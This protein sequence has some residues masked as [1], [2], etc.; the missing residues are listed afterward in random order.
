MRELKHIEHTILEKHKSLSKLDSSAGFNGKTFDPVKIFAQIDVDP[1]K[2]MSFGPKRNELVSELKKHEDNYKQKFTQAIKNSDLSEIDHEMELIES[3]EKIGTLNRVH[4]LQQEVYSDVYNDK[5]NEEA[6][7]RGVLIT[8]ELSSLIQKG[9]THLETGAAE[10]KKEYDHA[11]DE[12]IEKKKVYLES[13]K[14]VEKNQEKI[15]NAITSARL[16]YQENAVNN[17]SSVQAFDSVGLQEAGELARAQ[18]NYHFKTMRKKAFRSALRFVKDK[19]QGMHIKQ[20]WDDL[21]GMH[22]QL[23][24]S[25]NIVDYD[26]VPEIK[27]FV[28]DNMPQGN[29]V[30]V[31]SGI[32][33]KFEKDGTTLF[34]VDI[35]ENLPSDGIQASAEHLPF[36]NNHFD[37]YLAFHTIAYTDKDKSVREA[38]RVLRPGSKAVF[39]LH[40]S[41]SKHLAHLEQQLKNHKIEVKAIKY[42]KRFLNGKERNPV[43]PSSIDVNGNRRWFDTLSQCIHLLN[44]EM[45][46]HSSITDPKEKKLN[47]IAHLA[48][49]DKM[50][51]NAPK[52]MEFD[53]YLINAVKHTFSNKLEVQEFLEKRGFKIEKLVSFNHPGVLLSKRKRSSTAFGVVARKEKTRLNK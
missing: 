32:K 6:Q 5:V 25:V 46:V 41:K 29:V 47:K 26:A 9:G 14:R 53:K 50:L 8:N 40:H 52:I 42:F 43:I 10:A 34:P 21:Y 45:S 23:N 22:A 16:N 13:T 30:D 11:F 7:K 35:I 27:R 37:G 24:N 19:S 36:K 3:M 18:A 31:G 12:Y 48:N 1:I 20:L 28:M 15:Q 44:Q 38:F 2:S 4:E 49:A 17:F 33:S 51:T 39:L